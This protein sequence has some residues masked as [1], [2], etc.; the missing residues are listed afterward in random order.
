MG[1]ALFSQNYS[2]APAV[3]EE[4]DPSNSALHVP[5]E[6]WSVSNQFDPDSEDFF[7][8]A[9]LEHFIDGPIEPDSVTEAPHVVVL[10]DVRDGSSSPSSASS[11]DSTDVFSDDNDSPMAVGTDDPASLL[12]GAYTSLDWQQRFLEAGSDTHY[13]DRPPRIPHRGPRRIGNFRQYT[14][15][16][17]DSHLRPPTVSV[18]VP[19]APYRTE[20]SASATASPATQ[21]RAHDTSTRSPVSRRTVSIT[22]INI[23]SEPS[24]PSPVSP[25]TPTNATANITYP[26]ATNSLVTPSP[27]PNTTPRVYTWNRFPGMANSPTRDSPL[28]N[29]R[30]RLSLNRIDTLSSPITQRPY[31]TPVAVYDRL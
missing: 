25:T 30:A 1:R 22:P 20:P 31:S 8:D 2:S 21:T 16:A 19:P 3:R 4:P 14:T 18:F 7:R 27:A 17:P 10:E 5:C 29:P 23:P 12:A 13:Q 24:L 11:D 28:T 9:Q 26:N 15:A 6:N